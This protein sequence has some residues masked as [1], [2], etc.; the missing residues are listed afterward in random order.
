[1]TTLGSVAYQTAGLVKL[2]AFPRTSGLSIASAAGLPMV[3]SKT[4]RLG[5]DGGKF[6]NPIILT[7][8]WLYH[9]YGRQPAP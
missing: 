7:K 8:F 5:R 3:T 1:M 4:K 6:N 2:G 9:T